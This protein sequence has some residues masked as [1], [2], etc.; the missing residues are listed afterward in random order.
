[1]GAPV[2]DDCPAGRITLRLPQS[3]FRVVVHMIAVSGFSLV[4]AIFDA[5]AGLISQVGRI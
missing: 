2:Y 5:A 4:V 3:C 1:V